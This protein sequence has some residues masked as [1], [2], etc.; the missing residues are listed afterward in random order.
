MFMKRDG[1]L[2]ILERGEERGVVDVTKIVQDLVTNNYLNF[3]ADNDVFGGDPA[4]DVGKTLQL[5]YRFG[6]EQAVIDYGELGNV[7]LGDGHQ[8]LTITRALYGDPTLI[9]NFVSSPASAYVRTKPKL[10]RVQFDKNIATFC[11]GMHG[12]CVLVTADGEVWHW[13]EALDLTRTIFLP[14]KTLAKALSKVGIHISLDEEPPVIL[15]EPT[16][17]DVR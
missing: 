2:W 7:T 10:H 13:G 6:D 4:F 1:S 16:R 11:G 5:T 15:N 9:T 17:L 8:P 3:R 12:L 14:V